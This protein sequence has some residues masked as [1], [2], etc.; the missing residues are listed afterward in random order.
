[1]LGATNDGAPQN[2]SYS[3]FLATRPPTFSSTTEPM[4]AENFLRMLE[5]KFGLLN[6][7]PVQKT[8]FAAQQL[9]GA[10][11]AW[12]ANHVA[13]V[14]T[15]RQITWDE[16]KDA[17]RAHYI[18]AGLVRRKARE[19]A[20]L[21][22]GNPQCRGILRRVQPVGAVRP[23]QVDTPAKRKDRFLEGLSA[24]LQ[25]RLN[26]NMG[27]T[28]AEFVNNAIVAE[29]GYRRV[30]AERKRSASAMGPSS[31]PPQKFRMVY[32]TPSGQ[33]YR[34]APVPAPV[35]RPPQPA[36]QRPPGN[37]SVEE[38]CEEFNR[39][40]LY[41]PEQVDTPA[42]RKDRF[43]EGLSAELQDRLNL[44]MGG[45]FA[46]FV[47]NAI[48]AEDGY[49]RV[50]AERKRSAS[51]MGAIQW[52]PAEVPHG[53]HHPV[54]TEVPLRPRAG[55]CLC[56][57]LSQHSSDPRYRVAA[58]RSRVKE[59]FAHPS[60]Q[61]LNPDLSPATT[62]AARGIFS[63][64][65]P[66]PKKSTGQNPSRSNN[67]NNNRNNRGPSAERSGK[68]KEKENCPRDPPVSDPEKTQT[69]RGRAAPPVARR[70]VA[71]VRPT[72]VAADRR[73]HARVRTSPF[74]DQRAVGAP[75]SLRTL[76]PSSAREPRHCRPELLRATAASP[77]LPGARRR[78]RPRLGVFKL[79]A[80]PPSLS[81]SSRRGIDLV[82]PV[83]DR[84]FT[85]SPG[86]HGEP[87]TDSLL[88]ELHILFAHAFEL[89][90]GKSDHV[91]P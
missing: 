21:K 5:S 9:H 7:T 68:R 77:S 16:F 32:T 87:L 29:D 64:E 56:A 49:R 76:S 81:A 58:R 90:M 54:G 14:G 34:S 43:L 88:E 31:G 78:P 67:T 53:V 71:G 10:A 59:D 61:T 25:D 65:C 11:G 24:E 3:D 1:M 62:A 28:F 57:R 86:T 50:M 8:L 75:H 60:G 36:Q 19:F 51:A 70:V 91:F 80:K 39:L 22:Q 13:S 48:V 26:L 63:R 46:E 69:G 66:H 84:R 35:V 41:A 30:M 33:R 52:T 38:Y 82:L 85:A 74:A 73:A 72:A 40:A 45:T 27:G 12:W 2:S 37:R 18:P 23:E 44:N 79:H 15:D 55:T 47:N 83:S 17:F 89:G 4:E 6:C 42:K 20:A